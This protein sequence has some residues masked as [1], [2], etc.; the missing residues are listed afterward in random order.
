MPIQTVQQHCGFQCVTLIKYMNAMSDVAKKKI[1]CNLSRLVLHKQYQLAP[2]SHIRHSEARCSVKRCP[3]T[4]IPLGTPTN[5]AENPHSA[6]QPFGTPVGNHYKAL[7]FSTHNLK[8][9][10]Q[11]HLTPLSI[12]INV[13]NTVYL[14]L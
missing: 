12:T 14:N 3:P 13:K 1:H 6:L 8:F 11:V 10:V 4:S 5:L 2:R 7:C 9:K